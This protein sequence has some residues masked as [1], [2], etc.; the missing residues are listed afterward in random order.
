MLNNANEDPS[1]LAD[2]AGMQVYRIAGSP[3]A[4]VGYA[5]LFVNGEDK[6]LMV[7]VEPTDDRWLVRTFGGRDGNFYDGT[8]VYNGWTP[9]F[10]DVGEG[11]DAAFDLKEG[12]D[13]GGADLAPISGAVEAARAGA[14]FAQVASVVDVDRLSAMLAAEW[15][16]GNAD[17][18]GSFANNYRLW[19][20]SRGRALLAPWDMGSTFPDEGRDEALW[21][22]PAGN[23]AEL[24]F[25]DAECAAD[26][27]R[28]RD[29]LPAAIEDAGLPDA[30]VAARDRIRTAAEQDPRGVCDATR[31]ATAQ[32]ALLAW[33]GR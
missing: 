18:Y 33:F 9:Y 2:L 7:V 6:G 13:V 24:C 11:L 23:L 31:V 32:D 16:I 12:E 20:P 4:R 29:A 17:G 14:P 30:L 10:L 27:Q 8:Y 28:R 25:A 3:Y 1:Y 21:D 19:V 22:S 5:Q 26:Q 15:F